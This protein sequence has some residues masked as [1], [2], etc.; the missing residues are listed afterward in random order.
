MHSKKRGD[1]NNNDIIDGDYKLPS[2]SPYYLTTL[3]LK[4]RRLVFTL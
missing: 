1:S 4:G 3:K 2:T